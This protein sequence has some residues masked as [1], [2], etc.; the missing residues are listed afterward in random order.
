MKGQTLSNVLRSNAAQ[1][2]NALLCN[3]HAC[4][5]LHTGMLCRALL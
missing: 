3:P 2:G 1:V 5:T 4:R